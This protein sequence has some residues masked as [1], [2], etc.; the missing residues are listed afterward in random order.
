MEIIYPYVQMLHLLF[1]IIFLG[2][3]F[4]DVVIFG[5]LKVKFGENFQNVKQIISEKAVKIMPHSLLGLFLTGGIMMSSW[6]NSKI[7]YFQTPN[8]Q[9][10]MLKVAFA[11]VIA[12]GVIYSLIRKATGRQPLEFM[13]EHFHKIVL[14]LGLCIVL[15]AKIMHII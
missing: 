7:G 4:F 5:T 9:I 14:V 15:F 13:R 3:V 2:Y 11:C 6:V 1:A 12:L 10:F 8:Q